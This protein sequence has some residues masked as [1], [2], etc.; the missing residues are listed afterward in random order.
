MYLVIPWLL[1]IHGGFSASEAVGH[2]FTGWLQPEIE[3]G[4]S[5]DFI[6]G[7][8]DANLFSLTAGLAMPVS[9]RFCLRIGIQQ[10]IAG[11]NNDRTT[12]ALPSL[13]IHP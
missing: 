13:G 1:V 4:Y 5:H 2:R 8:E 7:G 11:Q 6:D 12:A 3:L 10:D 9:D